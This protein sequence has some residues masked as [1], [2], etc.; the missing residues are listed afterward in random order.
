MHIGFFN[1]DESRSVDKRT[2][3]YRPLTWGSEEDRRAARKRDGVTYDANED[4]KCSTKTTKEEAATDEDG[5]P[6][7]AFSHQ[8]LAFE[9]VEKG[10]I[11]KA[12]FTYAWLQAK[13]LAGLRE[14][15]S[16]Q[17]NEGYVRQ[18]RQLLKARTD[19]TL[20]RLA[21]NAA[22]S[23]YSELTD[24]NNSV[25]A[26]TLAGHTS[27]TT[28]E[29]VEDI[30]FGYNLTELLPLEHQW[31]ETLAYIYDGML[32]SIAA[33]H[34]RCRIEVTDLLGAST[35]R[36]IEG[37]INKQLLH[38][39]RHQSS[40]SPR[41]QL[42]EKLTV[43]GQAASLSREPR[44]ISKRYQPQDTKNDWELDTALSYLSIEEDY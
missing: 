13:P 14:I 6:I 8:E 30:F 33:A 3:D 39:W 22:F 36:R 17:S 23:L 34:D 27:L 1:S 44:R 10:A 5:H 42:I 15:A 35:A 4:R 28:F 7:P 2:L 18:A 21:R 43:N 32:K 20:N 19:G 31:S 16:R 41:D 26:A 40:P 12:T 38:R 37:A 25:R 9:A 24:I 29:E 11:P